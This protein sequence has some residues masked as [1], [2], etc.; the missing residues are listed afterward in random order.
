L[1]TFFRIGKH[2]FQAGTKLRGIAP[3]G[4][5]QTTEDKVKTTTTKQYPRVEIQLTN[6]KHFGEIKTLTREEWL[7]ASINGLKELFAEIG[8]DVPDV[9][10]SVGYPKGA[11]GKGKT[12]GQ[13]HPAILSSDDKAHIFIHPCLTD[14]VKVLAVLS[15]EL[16]HAIDNCESGHKGR[17]ARIAKD[18]GL[19][20]KMTA[21]TPS[22]ELV[23]CLNT[24]VIMLGEYPHALLNESNE[25][26]QST[27]M[28]KCEC[29]NCGYVVRTSRKWIIE[30]GAP[31]CPCNKEVMSTDTARAND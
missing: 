12:I 20:G 29:E 26:K 14:S 21:T 3:K 8:Q 9:Y 18:F 5:L 24:L 22:A 2:L 25:G 31:L 23:E 4:E 11:R 16:I 7:Q 10:V 1:V 13:C 28:I 15:H 17:F 19:E 30:L 6:P 27:R